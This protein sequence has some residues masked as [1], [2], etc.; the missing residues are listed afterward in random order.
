[1]TESRSPKKVFYA[2]LVGTIIVAI[3]CFTPILVILLIEVGLGAFTPYLDYVL[4]P[5]LAILIL[6]AVV[7]YLR[8]RR[9]KE[10][11]E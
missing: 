7:S 9:M 11:K 10:N 3:C 5:A 8:W 4:F 6:L 1:M 2:A